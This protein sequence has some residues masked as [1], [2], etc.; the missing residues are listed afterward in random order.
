[1]SLLTVQNLHLAFAGHSIFDD[2]GFQIGAGDRVGLI[3]PNGSGKTSLLRIL[4]REL[5][6][7]KGE[8]RQPKTTRLG[9]L[10]QDVQEDNSGQ[11]LLD[12]VLSAIP[13]RHALVERIEEAEAAM[14]VAREEEE[15]IRLGT[16]LGELHTELS[17]LDHRFPPHEAERVLHGL[18]FRASDMKRPL[19]EFSGGWRTRA[20]LA[21]I[22]HQ[23]PDVLLLDEPTNHLDIPSVRWLEDFLRAH[24][25]A[26]VLICHDRDFLNRQVR[27]LLSLEPEGLRDYSGNYDYY[28]KARAEEKE[29]LEGQKR[30]QDQ[31]VKEA[32]RFIDR[33]RSKA[34]K[35]R[36]A[37]SKIKLLEK[38]ELIE[39]HSDRKQVRFRFPDVERPGRHVVSLDGLSKAFGDNVLYQNLNLGI[40]RG[41]R[42][43]VIGE[44]GAGK[45]TLLKIVAGEL[46]ATAGKVDF[47]HKV[48]LS[49]Y[50]QHQAETLSMTRTILEEVAAAVPGQSQ[51]YVRG[52]CGAFLFSGDQV[53][54]VVQV[55]SGGEKARVALARLLV[56]KGNF[57]VMD[58]P[59]NHLDLES[60]EKL[61]EALSEYQGTVLLVSHNQ[62]FV[63]RL[64]TKIWDVRG[65]TVHEYPGTLYEYYAFLARSE[66]EAREAARPTPKAKVIAR[67]GDAG[68]A[69]SKKAARAERAEKR[70][71]ASRVVKPLQRRVRDLEARIHKL[72][73]RSQELSGELAD[74]ELYADKERSLPLLTEHGEVTKKLA[75]LMGRWEHATEEL[76]EAEAS[77]Y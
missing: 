8:I 68:A 45:T 46:D 44:N 48:N 54:K 51:T 6:P 27:R 56:S 4:A 34:T 16:H 23:K 21:G 58:E 71:Q 22:L 25:G 49:Y 73:T 74:P 10:P 39:T 64:A 59:T 14:E 72:E 50:A 5:A 55:L 38:M 26:I 63:N 65:G 76:E 43:A 36:Q 52:V 29:I 61:V 2:V 28:L 11:Q 12:S 18:G 32:K 47:G 24:Q 62:A 41:E 35:A 1:M 69:E 37:Q 75:E 66:K 7:D 17:E 13:G 67:E 77:L 40:E 33:F 60:T 3:G 31:K 19:T 30:N 15:Q 42:V 57:L 53:E 70:Q 20:A 9:Y